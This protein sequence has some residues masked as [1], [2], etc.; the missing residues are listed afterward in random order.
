MVCYY[1]L[2]SENKAVHRSVGKSMSYF[3][4]DVLTLRGHFVVFKDDVQFSLAFDLA[5]IP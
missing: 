5:G 4:V 1:A 3:I 2:T